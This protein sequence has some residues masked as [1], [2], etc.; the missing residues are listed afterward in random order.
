MVEEDTEGGIEEEP[1]YQEEYE[2]EYLERIRE[3]VRG[4]L[5]YPLIARRMG[6]E[7]TV[8]VCFT[9]YPDGA[10]GNLRV[11]KSSGFDLLDRNALRAVSSAAL[12]F[13]R[14]RE[15]VTVV[16]PITYRLE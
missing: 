14:P 3:V 6:W 7:G 2:R 16:L 8:V 9:L 10:I 15:P 11:E 4:Y 12:H 1:S 13:P 5:S